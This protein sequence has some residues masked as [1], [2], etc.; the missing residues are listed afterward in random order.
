MSRI[1]IKQVAALAGVSPATVSRV[2]AGKTVDSAMRARVE[3]AVGATG[4]RPN[5]AARRLR[6]Q[7]SGTIGLIV[8]DIRN[9]FFTAVSRA[10]EDAAFERGLRVI[11][12]NTD[13]NPAKEQMYLRLMEEE[14]VT[15]AIFA[16]TSQGAAW[17]AKSRFSFPLVLIDR[18]VPE[19]L[20]D[21]VVLDNAGA[22]AELVRHLHGRGYRRIAGFFGAASTTGRERRDGYET[23][24]RALGLKPDAH[25]LDHGAGIAEA[26]VGRLLAEEDRPEALIASNG[27]MLLGVVRALRRAGL[28][29]PEDIALAGFDNEPWTEI[30]GAGIT[31]MEQPV[32]EIGRNA[33]GMLLDRSAHPGG[34]AKRLALQARCIVRG[35]TLCLEPAG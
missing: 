13:E 25:F 3:E 26:A 12:C 32:E 5:L 20:H 15:G 27:L 24:M 8:A 11:L 31:V 6:S 33:M 19:A 17:V 7:E 1:G 2:L 16:P 22:S 30:V 35:S 4:Y 21:T 10:V 29:I 14:R 28:R 9:P 18:S 34:A 23:T